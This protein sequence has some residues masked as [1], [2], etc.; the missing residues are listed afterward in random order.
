MKVTNSILDALSLPA[1]VVDIEHKVV[2]W[3][4]PCELLTGV[5]AGDVIGT[6]DHWKAFY[7]APRPC[8]ADLVL[9]LSLIHI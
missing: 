5:A 4:T 9:D 7:D 6:Q 8:L 3:N 2:A 1:F